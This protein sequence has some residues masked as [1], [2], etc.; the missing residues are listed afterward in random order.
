MACVR[1]WRGEW[2]VDWYDNQRKR[3]RE[4][5]SS[6]EDG[7]R[8]LAEIEETDKARPLTGTLQ[9]YGEWWLVNHA[10]HTVKLSTYEEYS[11]CLKQH[12]Y[13]TLGGRAFRKVAPKQIRE[14]ISVKQSEGLTQ[15][16]IRNILA[17]IRGMYN[18]A[19]TDGD[20][21]R[22]PASRMGKFNSKRFH[23]EPINP[24]CRQEVQALLDHALEC[25]P[26]HYPLF[27]SA[28]RTGLRMGELIGLKAVDLDFNGWFINVARTF[29]RGRITLPKSGKARRVDMSKQLA[30]TLKE[31]LS[32]RR[33]K[34]LQDELQKPAQERRDAATVVN[35]VMGDWLFQTPVIA[36]SALA[37]RRR[38]EFGG[39]GGTQVDPS[40]LRKIFNRVLT[41]A[42]L[43][44]VRFHDL[45]HTYAS[46]LIQQGESLAYVKEQ[47]GHSSI[48]ITVDTYG[49]L[50]PGGNR[51]AVDKLDERL[52][53]DTNHAATGA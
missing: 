46:L 35:E 6:K 25:S 48:K 9:E 17:P 51:Q 27:L 20:V 37:K 16:S 47:M 33:A 41:D 30:A 32:R 38:P 29:Y 40:N 45:R 42:K 19:L 28:L 3:H 39:R 5:V 14:L 49:H 31:L 13:P 4:K 52:A 8:R 36:R 44:R 15:A 18:L 34:A 10:K 2:V 11:R 43:R 7:F 12:V 53:L 24:L 23:S 26:E 22:N 50:V 21:S 1:K